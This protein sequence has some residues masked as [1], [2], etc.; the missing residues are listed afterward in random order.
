MV[1]LAGKFSDLWGRRPFFLA[2]VIL[3]LLGTLLTPMMLS[4]MI[5]AVVSGQLISRLRHYKI[6][7]VSGLAVA[8]AGMFY[9]GR[10]P[11]D[12]THA[13]VVA[14]MIISGAGM[15]IAMPAKIDPGQVLGRLM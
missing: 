1:L 12:A 11:V 2:G 14:G 8:T 6:F 13:M 9:L 3:F 10:L 4:V 7:A 5:A 15:G